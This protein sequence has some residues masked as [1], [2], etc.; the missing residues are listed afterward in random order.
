VISNLLMNAIRHTPADGLVE[1]RGRA[2]ADG[3]ELSVTDEC[4][5]LTDEEMARVFDV[6]WQGS[7]ARSP[8]PARGEG[9]VAVQGSG[10]GLGLAIVR[11]IVEAH[12]GRVAV[13][14]QAPGCRFLVHLPG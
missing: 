6:A 8:V 10:A 2:V 9:P 3:V 14:N 4:G 13:A 11:G 1:V 12:R 7:T 5:G